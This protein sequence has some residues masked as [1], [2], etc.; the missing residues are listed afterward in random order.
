MVVR[1]QVGV[2]LP[3]SFSCDHLLFEVQQCIVNIND[4]R[5]KKLS[6]KDEVA[7]LDS[8]VRKLKDAY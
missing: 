7:R 3:S 1:E 6:I 4:L 8:F 5:E 2:K